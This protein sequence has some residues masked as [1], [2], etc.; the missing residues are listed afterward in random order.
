MNL[1]AVWLYRDIYRM[2][3]MWGTTSAIP[4]SKVKTSD[5]D[6]I[7]AL[8]FS[9]FRVSLLDISPAFFLHI[10]SLLFCPFFSFLLLSP[11]IIL[12]FSLSITLTSSLFLSFS[13][14]HSLVSYSLSMFLSLSSLKHSLSF[15]VLLLT[16]ME[17]VSIVVPAQ[18]HGGAA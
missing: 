10:L 16:D 18:I 7:R 8:Q 5:H 12:H 4:F 17:Q 15:S 6:L 11:Y 3:E 1:A 9:R 2:L 14:S 13:L